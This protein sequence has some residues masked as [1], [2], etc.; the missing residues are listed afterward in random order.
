MFGKQ[1][2]YIYAGPVTEA[3][4]V[5][6]TA[7]AGPADHAVPCDTP[8][9]LVGLNWVLSLDHHPTDAELDEALERHRIGLA[10]AA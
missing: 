6:V 8:P 2:W 5:W 10:A 3:R 9:W 7:V 1:Y 4:Q